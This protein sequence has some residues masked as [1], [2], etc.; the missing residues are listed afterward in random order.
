[1]TSSGAPHFRLLFC[2]R[3]KAEVGFVCKVCSPWM[4]YWL[5]DNSQVVFHRFSPLFFRRKNEPEERQRFQSSF[6]SRNHCKN[7]GVWAGS[8][9]GWQPPLH[10]LVKHLIWQLLGK[11]SWIC[12]K[13]SSIS[14]YWLFY[15]SWWT[16][17]DF[18]IVQTFKTSL[19]LQMTWE[20]K[21]EDL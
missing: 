16:V 5:F 4:P 8:E 9:L 12:H 18:E 14:H 17:K 7:A 19:C 15:R 20:E 2:V 21:K 13:A 10:H 11:C 6:S 3:V 1:M